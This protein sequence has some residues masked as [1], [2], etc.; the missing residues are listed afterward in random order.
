MNPGPV[1]PVV[2]IV[3]DEELFRC[4]TVDLMASACPHYEILQAS[5][6][7]EA[8]DLLKTRRVDVI[9]TDI[10]MPVM[11]G[12]ELLL[13]LRQQEARQP[14][15]VITAFGSSRIERRVSR[16]GGF[17]YIEKPVHMPDLIAMIQSAVEVERSH[18]EGITLPGFVQ[19][20]ELERKTCCLRVTWGQRRGELLFRDGT[21]VDA[22]CGVETGNAAALEVL[23]WDEGAQLDLQTGI[24][25]KRKTVTEPLSHLLLETMRLK[26]EASSAPPDLSETRLS[27]HSVDQPAT[28][29][30][31]RVSS[32]QKR[33]T[34]SAA[35]C[36]TECMTIE[37][38]IGAA[39]VDHQSGRVLAQLGGNDRLDLGVAGAGNIRVVRA[40]LRVME[41]LGFT[42]TME[43]ILVTLEDQYHLM[44]ILSVAP[45]CFL[46]LALERDSA[47]L[48]MAR[49]RLTRL[50][51]QLAV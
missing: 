25:P 27:E 23:G 42:N 47:N 2:L 31:K 19:L 18:I 14:V 39:L 32:S 30:D 21:L 8:L 24:L 3:D 5:H 4:S 13:A 15:I 37:G 9:V 34:I 46:Y 10:T 33:S 11:N 20:L 43:D 51:R 35:E 44:R 29:P 22:R 17:S 41:K 36:L 48:G 16:Y 7:R 12:L 49:H 50:E 38:A 40:K 6:G 45:H 26:D 28:K 1:N